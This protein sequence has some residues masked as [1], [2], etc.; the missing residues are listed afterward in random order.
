MSSLIGRDNIAFNALW[1]EENQRGQY[2]LP[3]PGREDMDVRMLGS[4]RPFALEIINAKAEHPPAQ[5]FA[6]IKEA[7]LASGVGVE[8]HKLQ[9]LSKDSV[10]LIRV[11]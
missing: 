10:Q 8:V 4:G 11:R 2:F 9:A 5:A 6:A 1:K 3:W 7:L